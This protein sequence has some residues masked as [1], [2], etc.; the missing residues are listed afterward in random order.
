[1]NRL[2]FC[3]LAFTI[4]CAL[5]ATVQADPEVDRNLSDAMK[6]GSDRAKASVKAD[7]DRARADAGL[8]HGGRIDVGGGASVGGSVGGD[9]VSVDVRVDIDD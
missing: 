9:K 3:A 6:V 7:V 5:G 1:M 4:I 2:T 8:D